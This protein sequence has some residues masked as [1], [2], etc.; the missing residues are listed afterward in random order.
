MV[1]DEA[2]CMKQLWYEVLLRC[3]R[4]YIIAYRAA[5]DDKAGKK[6][7][8]VWTS[9]PEEGM[10]EC[11]RFLVKCYGDMA[12]VIVRELREMANRKRPNG[13]WAYTRLQMHSIEGDFDNGNSQG[14]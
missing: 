1:I 4:D 2:A 9:L 3:A 8:P 6:R 14:T 7:V 12:P 11:E 5:M 10:Q 13:T